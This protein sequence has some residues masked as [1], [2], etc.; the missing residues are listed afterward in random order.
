MSLAMDCQYSISSGI[1]CL[2]HLSGRRRGCHR[3]WV[4]VGGG[5]PQYREEWYIGQNFNW[6]WGGRQDNWTIDRLGMGKDKELTRLKGDSNYGAWELRTRIAARNAG[7]LETLN[8]TDIQPTTGPNSKA[9]KAWK[10][11]RD[12]AMDLVVKRMEDNTLTHVRGFEEDPAGLWRHL[13][14]LYADSGVGAALRLSRELAAV[15]WKGAGD[16]MAAVVGRIRD[17]ADELERNHS[18]RPTDNQIIAFMLNSVAGHDDFKE[19]IDS[20]D[21]SKE[22]VTIDDVELALVRKARTLRDNG[23]TA[24]GGGVITINGMD[25]VNAMATTTRVQCSNQKCG[26]YGHTIDECFQEGGGKAGQIP[27]WFVDL[28]NRRKAEENG[29][30]P[31]AGLTTVFPM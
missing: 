31:I 3:E 23:L 19:L 4:E 25:S 5:H 8:G 27:Q 29:S 12:A 21:R 6:I 16:D 28:K 24:S 18:E 22:T 14:N 1:R 11:R 30:A 13:G 7:V 20:Y 17:I 9:Y 10:N 15:R 2:T 26:R